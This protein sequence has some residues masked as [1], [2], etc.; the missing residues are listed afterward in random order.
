[1]QSLNDITAPF[2]AWRITLG[3]MI[4]NMQGAG[5]QVPII[6]NAEKSDL[7]RLFDIDQE[8]FPPGI[9]YSMTEMR[10][11]LTRS[12][13][14]SKVAEG[15]GRIVGFIIGKAEAALQAHIITLDVI[16][17]ARRRQVGSALMEALH[18]EFRGRRIKRVVLEV[19][20]NNVAAQQ[21]YIFFGYERLGI[22]PGYY[23][24]GSDAYSMIVKL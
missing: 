23:G 21:F 16:P 10:F 6:R 7:E 5:P 19:A 11:Y 20:T 1:M 2:P 4:P 9:A 22:L 17:E 8:C 15:D 12:G 13:S 3:C 24:E 18:T 14:I